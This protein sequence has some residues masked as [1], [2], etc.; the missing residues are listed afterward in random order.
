MN[1]CII[2]FALAM[3]SILRLFAYTPAETNAVVEDALDYLQQVYPDNWET[4]FIE[5][6]DEEIPDTW[7]NFLGTD[8]TNGWTHAEKRAAFDWYLDSLGTADCQRLSAIGKRRVRAALGQCDILNHTNSLPYLKALALNPR[9]I[10]REEAIELAVKFGSVDDDMTRFVEMIVTNITGYTRS[11]RGSSA[12]GHYMEKI[13]AYEEATNAQDSAAFR[14]LK[15]F[16]RNRY[17]DVAGSIALDVAL[18]RLVSEY[19][20]SSNRLENAQFVLGHPACMPF[21]R[22]YFTPVTNQL[23]SAPQPLPEVEALRGL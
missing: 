22:Q 3:G 10:C 1:R 20:A 11:E 15:M 4:N 5:M 18:K 12:C 6:A 23:M 9:G 7:I 16:Y 14:A 21:D 13:L 17:V 19:E 2:M 8:E